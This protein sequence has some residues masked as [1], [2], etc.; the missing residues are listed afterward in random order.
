MI[1]P[2]SQPQEKFSD[3]LQARRD[4]VKKLLVL[5]ANAP[6]LRW[7]LHDVARKGVLVRA[8]RPYPAHLFATSKDLRQN[9]LRWQFTGDLYAEKRTVV[10]GWQRL[11]RIS[12]AMALQSCRS[13]IK[14]MGGVDAVMYTLP[15]YAGV[16][17]QLKSPLKIYYAYD[18]YFAYGWE[19]SIVARN[20]PAL[21]KSCDMSFG[22][23]ELL[24]EDFRKIT[25]KPV[26][27][28]RMAAAE[29]FVQEVRQPIPIPDDVKNIPRPIV[30]CTG[31]I[32]HTYDWELIES[33]SKALPQMSFVFAG[34][35]FN[36]PEHR[37]RIEGVLKLPNVHGLGRKP[38]EQLPR[39]L[40][41]FDVC[42]NPLTVMPFNDRRS[43]LR[44]YD[45]LST[46]KPILS[47]AVSEAFTHLPLIEIFKTPEE[48]VALLQKVTSPDHRVDMEA[49]TN[50]LQHNTWDARA[51]QLLT[52]LNQLQ[53][54]S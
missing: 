42:L 16:A 11:P 44:L 53:P 39:Y 49:R 41:S 50:Y 48:A 4:V 5:D 27:A 17:E 52:L 8:L 30:G 19:A 47:T 28:L 20:E 21:L 18:A 6:W 31:Q 23:S 35:V 54:E 32:N 1:L 34:P 43:P 15:Q 29:S 33:L 51:D 7:L 14:E 37:A 2:R 45:Y 38:H 40:K 3:V 25:N 46:D 9:L 36:E 26:Y 22:V 24:S 12:T 10:M 13:A